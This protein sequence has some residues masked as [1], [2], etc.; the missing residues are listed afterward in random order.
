MLNAMFYGF[1]RAKR[2]LTVEK[3]GCPGCQCLAGVMQALSDL[4]VS[5]AAGKLPQPRP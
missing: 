3:T 4:P 5:V 2:E 1:P